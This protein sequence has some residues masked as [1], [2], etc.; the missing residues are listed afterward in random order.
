M[1]KWER[2]ELSVLKI[3][4]MLF[5]EQEDMLWGGRWRVQFR[6]MYIWDACISSRFWDILS[7]SS[8]INF[9]ILGTEIMLY[10]WGN[11]KRLYAERE[12][13]G[14]R[15]D[16]QGITKSRAELAEEEPAG[17]TE[18]WLWEAKRGE[19]VVKKLSWVSDQDDVKTEGWLMCQ[20]LLGSLGTQ[21]SKQVQ[22]HL[23]TWW[24]LCV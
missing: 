18:G 5:T 14:S 12:K 19:R 6:K 21:E 4:F 8:G 17:T 2:R 23:T 10:W 1:R 20:M 22:S 3:R 16:D 15:T 24:S 9:G 13:E 7:W 11:L